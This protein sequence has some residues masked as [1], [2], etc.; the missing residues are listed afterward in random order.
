MTAFEDKMYEMFDVY[1]INPL[2]M[3]MTRDAFVKTMN[4]IKADVIDDCINEV[5]STISQVVMNEPYEEHLF[6]V[7]AD[8]QHEI[9]DLL[10][11]MKEKYDGK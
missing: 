3:T 11:Q 8:R 7:V 1:K 5:V 9:I 4:E 10:K 2:S 6:S